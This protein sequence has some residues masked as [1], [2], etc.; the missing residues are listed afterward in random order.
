M[1]PRVLGHTALVGLSPESETKVA[2]T[3]YQLSYIYGVF[4]QI[5][6]AAFNYDKRCICAKTPI[7]LT[8]VNK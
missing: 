5:L 4:S 1:G 7:S 6:F 3:S 2:L 8:V